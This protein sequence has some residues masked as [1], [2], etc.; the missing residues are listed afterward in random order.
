[1]KHLVAMKEARWDH[2]CERRPSSWE[3]RVWVV[4]L[5]RLGRKRLVVVRQV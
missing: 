2:E 3:D 1:M 5:K 4:P